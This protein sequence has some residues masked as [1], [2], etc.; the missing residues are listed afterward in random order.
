MQRVETPYTQPPDGL[1]MDRLEWN[2]GHPTWRPRG[3][4][5]CLL[6]VTVGGRGRVRGERGESLAVRGDAVLVM[7]HAPH[8]F[9]P[10]GVRWDMQWAHFLPTAEQEEHLRWGELSPGL[11]LLRLGD[12]PHLEEIA[13]TLERG[14]ARLRSGQTLAVP[15]AEAALA[16]AILLCDA[17]NPTRAALDAR[18]RSAMEYLGARLDRPVRLPEV[19]RAC[20]LS[21]SRL[22][23]LF[24][25]QTGTTI[26]R[27]LETQRLRLAR[28]RLALTAEPISRIA[29]GLGFANPFYF[30]R[31]FTREVGMSPR[32]FRNRAQH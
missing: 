26:Q 5:D 9:A 8:D 19:A 21:V 4:P 10:D 1:W 23:R 25:A 7:A 29:E 2:P 22:A 13:A 14:A 17:R 27:F 6:M 11:R 30:T 32:A 18:V 3:T 12:G 15:L 24:R 20:G 16:E 28:Q 31:R